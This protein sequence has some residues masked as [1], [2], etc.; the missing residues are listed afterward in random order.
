MKNTYKL[1]KWYP[2]LPKDWEV[3]M[4]VGR[5][6]VSWGYSPCD[7]LYTQKRITND[8][9]ENQP[10]YWTKYLFTT[11]DGVDIYK[12]DTYYCVQTENSIGNYYPW[13]IQKITTDNFPNL[14]SNLHSGK[15]IF[16][17]CKSV[18][19]FS[20]KKAAQ[21]YIDENTY[22]E[23][24]WVIASIENSIYIGRYLNQKELG[25]CLKD[26]HTLSCIK[27]GK[28]YNGGL[29]NKVERKATQ[30][31]I[32]TY[33]V[34][35]A[36]SKGFK[37]GVKFKS[38]VN[39]SIFNM[40]TN[41]MMYLTVAGGGLYQKD[42][43]GLI[44]N[45]ITSKWA[46][47][48]EE[49][50]EFHKYIEATGNYSEYFIKGFIYEVISDEFSGSTCVKLGVDINKFWNKG[51]EVYVDLTINN[52]KPSTKEEYERQE[53]LREL[54]KKFP[55]GSTVRLINDARMNV[56][57]GN[58]A[59]VKKC[60]FDKGNGYWKGGYMLDVE[61]D[62]STGTTQHDGGYYAKD[63]EPIETKSITIVVD[64]VVTSTTFDGD[65]CEIR[66]I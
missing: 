55:V 27:K 63:F 10:E 26:W 50:K 6:D 23:G 32:E 12:G 54:Q 51:D 4:T 1:L 66:Y 33:L 20:T 60:Y 38:A 14:I 49:K 62:R 40:T 2:T 29:F 25:I 56:K 34:A 17:E 35:I 45:N 5:G 57:Y 19:R 9:V 44:Y 59:T 41:D 11:E 48:I 16:T 8:C 65:S 7:V 22:K 36:K 24:D 43:P 47:I 31:E 39:D 61:W 53:K 18:I 15:T 21:K 52:W 3:G 58:L 37:K 46:T 28:F 13:E 30:E 42:K 64:G